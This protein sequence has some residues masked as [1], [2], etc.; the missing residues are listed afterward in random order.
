MMSVTGANSQKELATKLNIRESTISTWKER[1]KIP[2]NQ[3]HE[4]AK[5]YGVS[6]DSLTSSVPSTGQGEACVCPQMDE[7]DKLIFK[8]IAGFTPDQK[9]AII[10]DIQKEKLLKELLR[11]RAERE[12]A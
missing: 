12:A 8:S 7:L 1:G 6:I 5:S 4:F 11:E 9:R 2:A 3:L 10:E